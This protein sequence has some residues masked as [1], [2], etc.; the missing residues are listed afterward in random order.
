MSQQK[1]NYPISKRI[2]RVVAL[3]ALQ[4]LGW[5]GDQPELFLDE[6]TLD[7]V[8]P[9]SRRYSMVFRSFQNRQQI[10]TLEV[11]VNGDEEHWLGGA[12][13]A[14]HAT[15]E[16]KGRFSTFKVIR[17][18]DESPSVEVHRAGW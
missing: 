2:V 15:E 12:W 5:C 9:R 4:S 8:M 7:D 17:N 3:E 13:I 10:C 1:E 11:T 18:P 14:F 16:E 6:I